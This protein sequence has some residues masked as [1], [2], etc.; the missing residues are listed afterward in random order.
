MKGII[1]IIDY[2]K[3]IEI[4]QKDEKLNELTFGNG[5]S[6]ESINERSKYSVDN[7]DIEIDNILSDQ[8]VINLDI[9]DIDQ[10]INLVENDKF[11]KCDLN[12]YSNT[13][14]LNAVL[15]RKENI[16]YTYEYILNNIEG[17]FKFLN[18]STLS[19]LPHNLFT[20]YPDKFDWE[21]ISY[22]SLSE[23]FIEENIDNINFS[24][25]DYTDMSD[26]FFV[27]YS[28]KLTIPEFVFNSLPIM[29]R[30][31]IELNKILT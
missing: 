8:Y 11:I 18:L 21:K 29:V 23:N 25:L 19:K 1:E 5:S 15:E 28:N 14:I 27:K 3:F 4:S 20:E 17:D 9:S 10:F 12:D 16:K 7:R 30:R 22:L 26:S 6:L 13:L 2:N 31:E 24:N